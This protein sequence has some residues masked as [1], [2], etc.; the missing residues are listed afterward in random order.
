MNKNELGI[1]AKFF[2]TYGRELFTILSVICAGALYLYGISETV[3]DLEPRVSALE[4]A[5]I[6]LKNE[7]QTADNEIR[8]E[9]NDSSKKFELMSVKLETSLKEISTDLQFIKQK[10]LEKSLKQ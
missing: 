10:L 9:L 6:D 7:S 2:H 1:V 4:S 8:K 3:K 5:V